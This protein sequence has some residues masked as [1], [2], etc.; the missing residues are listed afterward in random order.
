MRNGVPKMLAF[1]E[2]AEIVDKEKALKKGNKK[3][4]R[5]IKRQQIYKMT[6]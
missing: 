6:A 2:E 3:K 4:K 1:E 5:R